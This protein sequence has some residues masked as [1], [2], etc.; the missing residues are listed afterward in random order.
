MLTTWLVSDRDRNTV[1][2]PNSET[3]VLSTVIHPALVL[4]LRETDSKEERAGDKAELG[5]ESSKSPIPISPS[6]P[7]PAPWFV[8]AHPH[9]LPSTSPRPTP[10][11]PPLHAQAAQCWPTPSTCEGNGPNKVFYSE[12]QGFSLVFKFLS[13]P[14]LHLSPSLHPVCI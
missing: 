11:P 6:S 4:L 14:F 8:P 12:C 9:P 2:S 3:H 13:V 5:A 7:A 1:R 10:P